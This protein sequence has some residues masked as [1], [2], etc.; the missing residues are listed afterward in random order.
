MKF[1]EIPSILLQ[2]GVPA[3]AD[4]VVCGSTPIASRVKRFREIGDIDLVVSPCTFIFLLCKKQ[5]HLVLPQ[6][7]HSWKEVSVHAEHCEAF[8]FW[9]I[10]AVFIPWSKIKKDCSLCN[11]MRLANLAW[12]KKYKRALHRE[13]DVRD[14]GVLK[15]R[16][17]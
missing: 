1:S 3:V 15:L 9:K 10:G 17:L 12:V 8:M 2:Q 4:V 6:K 16:H 11:G 13:K 5:W 14:L 7:G